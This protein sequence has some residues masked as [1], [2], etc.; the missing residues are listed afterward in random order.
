MT[1]EIADQQA[2][3]GAPSEAEPKLTKKKT[4]KRKT[5][6]KAASASAEA[7]SPPPAEEAPADAVV[8]KTR[9]RKKVAKKTPKKTASKPVAAD[10]PT[11]D[12]DSPAEVASEASANAEAES[13]PV[14]SEA[15][16]AAV[17]TAEAID[18]AIEPRAVAS[19]AA[20][21]P[22]AG[23]DAEDEGSPA[24]KKKRRRSRRKK[25]DSAAETTAKPDKP[26]KSRDAET[27]DDDADDEPAGTG[28]ANVEIIVNYVPGEE[29]RVAF[30]EDGRLEEFFSEPTDRVSRVG[31]IYVGKV[32]NVESQIQA[33][34]VDFGIGEGG[35]LHA[36]DLHPR[37]FPGESGPERVGRKTP[38][39]ERPPLQQCLKRGQ[40]IIVQVLKEGVGTKGPS[41]TSYISVPGRYLVMM[42]EMDKVGVSRK[43]E[44][45]DERRKMRKILDELEL[46]DGFGFILRTAGFDRTKTELKR[47][48]AYLQRLWKDMEKRRK[49]GKGPRLLY[50]ESDLLLRTLR[51][52]LSTDVSRIVIDNPHALQRAASYLKIV[53]PRTHAHIERF[54]GEAPIYHAFGIEK[55]LDM[56]HAT[57]VP[58]PSGGRLIIE[59]T[60]ALVAID[61]NS[62]KSRSARD[63]ETNA[64]ET[65]LEAADEICRQLRLRDLGGLVI[66]DLIDMRPAANRRKV[67][68]RFRERLK[69]DRAKSTTLPIS[70]FGLLEMTRQ[71]MRGS[72]E[73][74]HFN[75]CPSCHGRGLVPKAD[76]VASRAIRE[77]ALLL[78]HEKIQK[79][80]LVVG[81]RVAGS[82]L[83]TR[84]A[85]LARVE[86]LSGKQID[87]RISDAMPGSRY[88]F[89]A[90]DGGG[91]DV[92]IDRLPNL[93]KGKPKTERIDLTAVADGEEAWVDAATEAE[94][95]RAEENR[96][97]SEQIEAADSKDALEA[98]LPGAHEP[99][100]S[101]DGDGDE[102]GGKKK[103]RRRRR[104]RRKSDDAGAENESGDGDGQS[105][106]EDRSDDA[107]GDAAPTP[108]AN[109][110]ADDADES[111]D[112]DRPNDDGDSEGKPKKRR[113]RRRRRR[114]GDAEGSSDGAEPSSDADSG[115]DPKQSAPPEKQPDAESDA[116][117][118]D[119]KP[120]RRRR[121]L[122]A[123]ARR[124]LSPS[125][126]ASIAKE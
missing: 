66:N 46:P 112:D 61:V 88:T 122:Y 28:A 121:G 37:Y 80:E 86:R 6:K 49:G 97:A 96:I 126:K 94:E 56:M 50:A 81:P 8:K 54:T 69:R 91:A 79:V 10:E 63:A 108:V 87:V 39:R 17:S 30:L 104:R 20:T 106:A 33:A 45:E 73:Q 44:D 100:S 111:S 51:D 109:A 57:E 93:S 4:R 27:A 22:E 38:R 1:D 103:R 67:E 12:A 41:L 98:S 82:L 15:E 76:S 55:Q 90:Y 70:D 114:S 26:A 7:E 16:A 116:D 120:R 117:D 42:P 125:E 5:T 68:A 71:R 59:Q 53:S 74:A 118:G 107:A 102:E 72:Y 52:E 89:Y 11:P 34:F 123:A 36:S 2:T 95:A 105:E 40:E 31:N 25:D 32:T 64:L 75:M 119:A 65:N 101:S 83:S 115:A 48:L 77:L 23:A 47:D 92:D 18:E 43:V 110:T 84:R 9:S 124:V 24:P 14:S 99:A 13:T 35:F 113:R 60:E 58:L 19:G 62:G 21:Q 3:S 85:V 29:C 78:Q